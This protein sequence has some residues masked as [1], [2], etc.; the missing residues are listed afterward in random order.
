[1]VGWR[2]QDNSTKLMQ[3]GYF[4]ITAPGGKQFGELEYPGQNIMFQTISVRPFDELYISFKH[5]RFNG[6]DLLAIVYGIFIFIN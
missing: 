3:S 1:M 2:T 6:P 4:G 5:K